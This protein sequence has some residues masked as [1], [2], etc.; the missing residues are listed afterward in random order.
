MVEAERRAVPEGMRGRTVSE[1]VRVGPLAREV[2][3]LT[4]R[5]PA[6]LVVVM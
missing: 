1:M 3:V 2:S 6:A 4:I 5:S